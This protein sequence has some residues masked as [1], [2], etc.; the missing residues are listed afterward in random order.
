M[1]WDWQAAIQITMSHNRR[2]P[3]TQSG[4]CGGPRVGRQ[5]SRTR[6]TLSQDW[7][8]AIQTTNVIQFAEISETVAHTPQCQFGEEHLLKLE[9]RFAKSVVS[10]IKDV[11]S[12]ASEITQQQKADAKSS[13]SGLPPSIVGGWKAPKHCQHCDD[14]PKEE[15]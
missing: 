10:Q 7:Q 8:G 14:H 4:D 6:R 13:P 3:P 12:I 9:S 5:P 11:R 1:M 2:R 15:P